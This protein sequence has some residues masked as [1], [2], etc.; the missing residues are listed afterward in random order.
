MDSKKFESILR[1]DVETIFQEILE[2]F[3]FVL[4]IS[5][6]SRSGAEISDYL[7]D[8]FVDYFKDISHPRI[9]GAEGSPKGKT[10]N[11]FDFKFEYTYSDE[12]VE[13]NQELIWADIKACK[14]TY[15]DSNPDIGTPKKVIK[16]MKD[17][18]FYLIYV[19]FEYE[20]TSDNKTRFLPF[21]NNKY[22]KVIFLKNIHHTVRINPKPQL[23]V[24]SKMP[25]EYRTEMQFIDL[26]ETKYN[27]SLDR[28]ME[29]VSKTRKKIK[30]DFD[31]IRNNM[32]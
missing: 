16:Y 6:K 23:Q 18:H 22:V 13:Y 1:N 28:I 25:E 31:E 9:T 19:M 20:P 7:E 8:A 4:D 15:D 5:A 30:K 21:E 3:N 12:D 14:K 26:L 11:P 27:E 17:G 2:N 29:N 24:N 32:K 10:K